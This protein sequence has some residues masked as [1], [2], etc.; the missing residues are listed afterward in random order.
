MIP[1][2]DLLIAPLSVLFVVLKQRPATTDIET[3]LGTDAPEL[4]Y[5][6]M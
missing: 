2:F 6:L 5:G 1:S 3:I 4:R